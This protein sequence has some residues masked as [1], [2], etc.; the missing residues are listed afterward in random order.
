MIYKMVCKFAN[1]EKAQSAAHRINEKIPNIYEI[2]LRY[3]SQYLE[4][5]VTSNVIYAQ[6]TNAIFPYSMTSDEPSE[7]NWQDGIMG[8]PQMEVSDQCYLTLLIE[9]ENVITAQQIIFN[10]GGYDVK[11]Y[12]SKLY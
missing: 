4:N 6:T 2:R 1:T 9:E 10:E 12:T 11:S 7:I 3:H 5:G 8:I